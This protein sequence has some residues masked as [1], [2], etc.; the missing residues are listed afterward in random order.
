MR[1]RVPR[2]RAIAATLWLLA[3]AGCVRSPAVGPRIQE[4]L[5]RDG[6]GAFHQGT[7]DGYRRAAAAF[8]RAAAVEPDNCRYTLHLAEALVFLSD[9]QRSNWEAY[10]A[11]RSEAVRARNANTCPDDA[12]F[13]ARLDAFLEPGTEADTLR[14]LV[15]ANPEDAMHW[16]AYWRL[17]SGRP[18]AERRGEIAPEDPEGLHPESALVQHAVGRFYRRTGETERA[19]ASFRR[20]LTL[21]PSHY[22]SYLELGHAAFEN[23]SPLAETL[24]GEVVRRAPGFLEGRRALGAYYEAVDQTEAAMAEYRA[25]IDAN[26]DYHPAHYDLGVLLLDLERP[27]EAEPHMRRVVRLDE[28]NA[29]AYYHLG[30]I[31]FD[32]GR[33]AWARI[34]YEVALAWRPRHINAEYGYGRA[35]REL[36]DLDEALE[37][38][39][40]VVELA[41]DSPEGYFA[42]GSVR[43]VLEAYPGAVEDYAMATRTGEQEILQTDARIRSASERD[44]RVARARRRRL[45]ERKAA[46]EELVSYAVQNRAAVETYLRQLERYDAGRGRVSGG[47]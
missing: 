40:R 11:S 2:R 28:S 34:Q 33:F 38:F 14:R 43:S 35:A 10:E 7:P 16:V 8:R 6:V 31:Q 47:H 39:E 45:E 19:G 37:R 26:P 24:Y 15:L 3:A 25:A 20:A 44:S 27:D 32:R 29:D 22:R 42:R 9:E 4:S 36:G 23:E 18:R 1:L 5:F 30:N 13:Q 41:P 17:V 46:L 12:D 21:N